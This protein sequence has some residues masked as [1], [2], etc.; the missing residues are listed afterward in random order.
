MSTIQSERK[1][2][3]MEEMCYDMGY[4]KGKEDAVVHGRWIQLKNENGKPFPWY[5]CS[6]CAC[7]PAEWENGL[8]PH[9][10]CCGAKMDLEDGAK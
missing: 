8:P 2:K 4:A 7:S 1:M 5:Q 3:P 10:H 9:C 6:N